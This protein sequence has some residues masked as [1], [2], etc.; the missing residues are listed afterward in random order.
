MSAISDHGVQPARCWPP[1]GA[2]PSID[3]RGDPQNNTNL[4]ARLHVPG[5]YSVASSRTGSDASLP[6]V[7]NVPCVLHSIHPRFTRN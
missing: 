7:K 4:G 5:A 6:I 3:N 2:Q 1:L